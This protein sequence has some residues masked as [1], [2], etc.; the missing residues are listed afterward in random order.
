MHRKGGPFSGPPFLF[1]LG[2]VHKN[3]YPHDYYD[4]ALY[5]PPMIPRRFFIKN[6]MII[7]RELYRVLKPGGRLV[8]TS[9]EAS[10]PP[11]LL[12]L[13]W[14]H[15][16]HLYRNREMGSMLRDVGFQTSYVTNAI[17]IPYRLSGLAFI[18]GS[19]FIINS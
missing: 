4:D 16:M 18:S 2:F 12:F 9:I 17:K 5:L 8:I 19:C 11:R 10:I 13:P 15:S 14:A 7:L 1:K 6:P 3:D